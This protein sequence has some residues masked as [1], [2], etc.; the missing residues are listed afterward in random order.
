LDSKFKIIHLPSVLCFGF[1]IQ[2]YFG[3]KVQSSSS[4]FRFDFDFGVVLILD[5]K[6]KIVHLSSVL[7]LILE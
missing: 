4:F 2:E 1:W 5:S 3:F 6:F 7:I